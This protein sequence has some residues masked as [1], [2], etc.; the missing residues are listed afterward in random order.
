M[1]WFRRE[2]DPEGDEEGPERSLLEIEDDPE[3][4]VAQA[5]VDAE[6]LTPRSP[7]P[8]EGSLA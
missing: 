2:A 7:I 3:M 6:P 1:G 8:P 4:Q 5:E